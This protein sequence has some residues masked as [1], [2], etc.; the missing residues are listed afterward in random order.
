MIN[1]N[2]LKSKMALFGDNQ[3]DLANALGISQQTLSLK[4]NGV[5]G[6]NF[7][8]DEIKIIKTKYNLTTE[9]VDEIFLQS[10]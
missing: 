4:M 5:N 9:E 7:N 2:L 3:G 10:M 1:K 8:V 6:A